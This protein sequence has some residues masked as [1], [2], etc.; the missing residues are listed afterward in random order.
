MSVIVKTKG[1]QY[2]VT[3]PSKLAHAL[4]IATGQEVAWRIKS[5]KKIEMELIK[6]ARKM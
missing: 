3:V 4:N 5:E 6:N 1:G 2:L